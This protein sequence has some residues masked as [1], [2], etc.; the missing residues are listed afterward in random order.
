MSLFDLLTFRSAK[1]SKLSEEEGDRN[2]LTLAQGIILN[3]PQRVCQ[4]YA[5]STRS[6]T[7]SSADASYQVIDSW[8]MPAGTMGLNSK[9]VII[10]DW[11]TPSSA[12]TKYLAVDFGGQN[13]SAPSVTA[14]VMGKILI[15][16][17]NLNSLSSQ[18]TA[19]GSS[20]GV[21]SNAR[22]ATTVDTSQDVTI[23]FKV[24][25]G[26]GVSGEAISLLG[27]SIYHYPGN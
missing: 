19:N 3:S 5:Q 16:T 4:R 13:I 22:L 10:P 18:K 2:V 15:E 14:S 1:G 12:S 20:Y 7:N 25:W 23:D 17:Q 11:D 6:S 26:A 27:F 8:I 21:T 9:L 24:K